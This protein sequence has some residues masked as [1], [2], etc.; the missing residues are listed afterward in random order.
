MNFAERHGRQ[1][2]AELGRQMEG[3]RY[4]KAAQTAKQFGP[5]LEKDAERK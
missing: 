4:Q 2:L 3:L 1:R 5:T